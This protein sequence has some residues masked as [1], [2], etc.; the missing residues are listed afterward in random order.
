MAT[1]SEALAIAHQAGK[2]EFAVE[3]IGQA[4]GCRDPR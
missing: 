3:Y 2:Q 1:I 4:I